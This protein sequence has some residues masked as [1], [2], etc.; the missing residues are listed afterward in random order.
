M[1]HATR[2]ICGS[3]GLARRRM[4][5]LA[6]TGIA[7]GSGAWPA[8]AQQRPSAAPAG[9]PE[10]IGTH[11]M[12]VLG[13]RTVFLSHLPMFQGLSPNRSRFATP[14]R[15][16]VILEASFEDQRT[17][18]DL[19]DLY[20]Q[21]RQRSPQT[22][23]YTLNPREQFALAEIIPSG[24]AAAAAR[25]AFPGDVFRGHLERG[26][27]IIE[28]LGRVTV[29]ILRVVHAREFRPGERRPDTLEYLL[30]GKGGETFLA[31]RIVA[32][33]DFDQLLPVRVTG[34]TL[35]DAE[36]VQAVRVVLQE[37]PNTVAGRLQDGQT[38]AAQL[39]TS[40][41]AAPRAITLQA[42]RE[43]YFEEGELAV[44]P[45]FDDTPA[46]RQAGF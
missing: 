40:G 34:Q 44:P 33:G 28:G 37:R 8:A 17:R 31:H 7:L 30:F 36:L 20:R 9:R 23:I 16:Q 10:D 5:G 3:G 4:L 24:T 6:A 26:G 12:L 25:G 45:N 39:V 13:E 35:S 21:D 29:R 14:H 2:A 1:T 18:R 43:I 46:E 32:P 19:T 38:S 22:R 11:N 15:F 42:A 41:T 27:Q